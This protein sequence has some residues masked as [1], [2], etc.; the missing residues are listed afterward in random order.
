MVMTALKP[1]ANISKLHP[2]S[3]IRWPDVHL[4]FPVSKTTW[5]AG[6]RS[7]KYPPAIRLGVRAVGWKLKD[8][9]QLID[10]S[11]NAA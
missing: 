9:L 2:E 10:D 1:T 5:E 3:V 4:I 7:G 6:V 8:V 11:R